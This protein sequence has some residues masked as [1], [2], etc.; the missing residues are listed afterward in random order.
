MACINRKN[1]FDEAISVVH[2]HWTGFKKISSGLAARTDVEL[3]H[4]SKSIQHENY[5]L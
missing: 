3:N 5:P 4:F 1:S 2:L